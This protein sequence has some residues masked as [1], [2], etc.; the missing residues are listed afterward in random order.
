MYTKVYQC[1]WSSRGGTI[2]Q[3]V[4]KN[5]GMIYVECNGGKEKVGVR[6][7]AKDEGI[8]P[9]PCVTSWDNLLRR[10]AHAAMDFMTKYEGQ[11]LRSSGYFRL[12]YHRPRVIAFTAV[13]LMDTLI[14]QIAG[15]RSNVDWYY[16]ISIWISFLEFDLLLW[17]EI[18]VKLFYAHGIIFTFR[19]QFACCI[20]S[21]WDLSLK[22]NKLWS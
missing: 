9:E 1:E 5:G 16:L 18:K 22:R 20:A 7:R 13:K 3:P 19:Y 15:A 12:T 21:T 11:W 10:S 6:L 8:A 2:E 14:V 4:G 17:R